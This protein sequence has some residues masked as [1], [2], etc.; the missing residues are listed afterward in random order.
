[1]GWA[2]FF[3]EDAMQVNFMQ[4]AEAEVH[5]LAASWRGCPPVTVVSSATDLPFAAPVD[6]R[7]AYFPSSGKAYIVADSHSATAVADTMAH[8]IIAHHGL[9]AE[10]GQNWRSFM[11]G[12]QSGARSGD[13][14]LGCFQDDVRATYA[15]ASGSCNLSAA[16]VSDEV[17][18]AIVESRF[19]AP[20][21]RM[22]VH[23]PIRARVTAALGHFHRDVLYRDVP[24]TFTQ[25]LGTILAAEHRLRHGD[26]FF[27]IGFRVRRWYAS[28]M[29]K[30]DPHARPMSISES[31]NLIE[32]D[33]IR[34]RNKGTWL[35]TTITWIA[36]FAFIA[37][38]A[39]AGA[40][41]LSILGRLF[42]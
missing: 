20:T 13:R 18:A 36:V 27:G 30:F 25:L 23:H 6:A 22:R 7:G 3:M 31:Q 11:F 19:H 4:Q 40:G 10:L 38:F 37:Y 2:G 16:L 8:E 21:G 15:D 14:E 33:E 26:G 1:M 42:R 34:D 41:F 12:M 5:R 32:A 9:R 28:A 29:P 17:A 35:Y 39:S 24:V